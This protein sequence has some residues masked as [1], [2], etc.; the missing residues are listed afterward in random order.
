MSWLIQTSIIKG[1]LC[2]ST[3]LSIQCWVFNILFLFITHLVKTFLYTFK[4]CDIVSMLVLTWP[5]AI[6]GEFR[7]IY[8]ISIVDLF[9]H[10]PIVGVSLKCF[11]TY[12]YVWPHSHDFLH[13]RNV[14]LPLFVQCSFRLLWTCIIISYT[15]IFVHSFCYSNSI[16]WLIVDIIPQLILNYLFC[17]HC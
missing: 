13:T 4:P 16:E 7:S 3:L 8:C 12:C 2:Q 1:H 14:A 10:A 5:Y 17:S 11:I 15:L 6:F 9:R